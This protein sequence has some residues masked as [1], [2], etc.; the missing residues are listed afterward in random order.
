MTD[1]T[2]EDK[3]ALETALKDLD[4]PAPR[5]KLIEVA[6][7]NNAPPTAVAAL[8]TLPETADFPNAA[9]LRE[10]LGLNVPGVHPGR[11]WE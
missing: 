4:Y 5:N 10:A 11:E 8:R 6:R 3:A 1:L 2:A 9:R 7:I